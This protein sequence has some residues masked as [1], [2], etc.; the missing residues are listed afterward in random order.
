MPMTC[1]PLAK[2]Q[3]Q[4]SIRSERLLNSPSDMSNTRFV[5]TVRR[6]MQVNQFYSKKQDQLLLSNKNQI[7]FTNIRMRTILSV[8]GPKVEIQHIL[9]TM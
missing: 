2:A 3:A 5:A 1:A 7:L 9:S 8:T 6:K 4:A